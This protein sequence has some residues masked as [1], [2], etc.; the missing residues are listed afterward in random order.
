MKQLL[1]S[2]A[3]L[4]A[5]VSYAEDAQQVNKVDARS[6]IQQVYEKKLGG[7]VTKPGSMQGAIRFV[8][9]QNKVASAEL[10]AVVKTLS[11]QLKHD[12]SVVPGVVSGLP[13]DASVTAAG[14]TLAVFIVDDASLP[15][16]LVAPEE[17]WALVNVAKMSVGLKDDAVGKRLLARRT[18]GETLRAFSLLCGGGS[19]SFKGNV[20]GA[21]SVKSLDSLDVD[22]LVVDMVPRYTEYLSSL[23]VT[24]PYTVPYSRACMEGWAP[25]PTNEFQKAAME[26]VRAKQSKEPTKGITIEYD[27]KVGR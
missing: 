3:V 18:R 23:G 16:A 24:P 25:T 4:G 12:I 7:F 10:E 15:T 21:T 26:R 14:A 2:V 8:N 19:S 17:R 13:S 20:F 11:T 9:A 1:L 27:P 5:V 22:A 6:K